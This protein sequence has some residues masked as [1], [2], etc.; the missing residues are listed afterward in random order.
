V[1][2]GGR[3][4]P[5]PP[6]RRPGAESPPATRRRVVGA[7]VGVLLLAAAVWAVVSQ[8]AVLREAVE[9]VGDAHPALIAAAFVLPIVSL[10]TTSLTFWLLSHRYARVPALDM[11]MLIGAAWLLN[12]LPLRPGMVGRVA[13][14]K[15]Y[16]GMA[17]GDAL[18]VMI[19]A[20]A[21]TGA[22]LGMLLLVAIGISRSERAWAQ[23]LFLAGPAILAALGGAV[24][25]ALGRAWWRELAAMALRSVDMLAWVGRYAI[26]FHLVGRPLSLDHVVAIAAVCQLAMVVPITG[27]GLGLRE[28]A[29]GL[30]L[31][32][33]SAP[34]ARE[35]A[36]AIGLAAD[37]VNRAAETL[38]AVPVGLL[39][40]YG[41]A[42]S[43]R[44]RSPPGDRTHSPDSE[45][46]IRPISTDV[47]TVSGPSAPGQGH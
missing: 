43:V 17:V 33:V 16:H 42:R 6:A 18:R 36:A 24:A 32:A 35:E 39:C 4:S 12:H 8:R 5:G 15:K 25:R 40:S 21:L 23:A 2:S 9:A 29:V 45:G 26:V 47:Q 46:P 14:H 38:L 13:F 41:L 37:L 3:R 1:S 22:S 10:V 28:W 11:L 34:G 19:S 30:T 27:N 44:R 7:T 20:M 31:A